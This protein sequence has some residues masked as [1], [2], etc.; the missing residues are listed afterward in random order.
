M[1]IVIIK[2]NKILHKLAVFKFFE[3]SI[4]SCAILSGNKLEFCLKKEFRLSQ[5]CIC[6]IEAIN[7]IT[8]P[9]SPIIKIG[10]NCVII[11]G[12]RAIICSGVKDA[13]SSDM[14]YV[15]SPKTN[16]IAIS[17][18]IIVVKIVIVTD[19]MNKERNFLR[20]WYVAK[21]PRYR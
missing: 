10:I 8:S 7:I 18:M 9:T 17:T 1:R 6:S 20:L 11:S 16:G 3:P 12:R 13:I 5:A 19:V 21:G 14:K 2:K 15:T 4:A